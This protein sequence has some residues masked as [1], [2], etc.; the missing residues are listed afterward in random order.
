MLLLTTFIVNAA[1]LGASPPPDKPTIRVEAFGQEVAAFFDKENGLPEEDVNQVVVLE[2]GIPYAATE[3]G[4]FHYTG[5]KWAK[6]ENIPD[7]PVI[8]LAGTLK[9]T[10]YAVVADAVYTI[11]KNK[12]TLL[13]K[14]PANTSVNCI[15][16]YEGKLYVGSDDGLFTAKDDMLDPTALNELLGEEKTVCSITVG[17]GIAVAAKSGL[18]WNKEGTWHAVMPR[19]E[20]RSWAPYDVRAVTFDAKNR[21]WFASPQGVGCIPSQDG[22][23]KLYTCE[24]GLP[25]DDFTAIA[26]GKEDEIFLGT[27]FGAIRFD[28]ENWAYRQGRRWLPA[29]NIRNVTCDNKGTAW[30]A[31]EKGVG[32][33]ERM[34]MTLAQ[35]AKFYESE[36]DKYHLRTE[37]GYVIEGHMEKPGDKSKVE[38]QDSDNDGLWTSM[39]GAGECFAYGATKAPEAKKRAKG[40]FEALR[41]LSVVTQGGSPSAREGFVARSVLPTS[42]QNPNEKR[43]TRETDLKEQAKDTL[44]K[45]LT[46]RWPTS[47]DGKWYWKCDT[48]SDELDGHFFFYGLYYDLVAET[49]EEKARVREVV[50]AIAGHLLDNQFRLVDW[51]GKPTRWA[52]FTPDELNRNPL[53]VVERG[54]N[55]LGILSYL[56]VAFHVTENPKYKEAFDKLVKEHGYAMNLMNAKYQYGIG[57]GNQS[58]DEMIFMNFYNVLHYAPDPDVKAV[59]ARTFYATWLLERPELNPFFNFIYASSCHGVT[60]NSQYGQEDLSPEGAW[61]EQSIDTLKH[62]PLDRCNWRHINSRRKDIVPLNHVVLDRD[63]K[64]LGSRRNG[65]VIPVDECFFE[66]YNYDPWHLDSGGSGTTIGSGTVFLLPYYMGLY[67]GFITEE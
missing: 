23:T 24:D 17:A 48:S 34:P 42:G 57:S 33:I 41:F 32:C 63:P 58:D 20:N 7:G 50:D 35:K 9:D 59:A 49:P 37:H 55:S 62:F 38:L 64:N 60:F 66:H 28:G 29:D 53:W 4:L 8:A 44:W 39:Y 46:P 2:D 6:V 36:I 43:Y 16:I 10:L 27:T 12:G 18:F 52:I 40:A 45:V 22:P 61:L 3:S 26:A 13:S 47:A 15:D 67:N 31:T 30:F 5:K 51:D 25:Y 1:L 54:M 14:L 65:Y 11:Q 19:T 56:S 21:L